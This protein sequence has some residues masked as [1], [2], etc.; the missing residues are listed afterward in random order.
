MIAKYY[1]ESSNSSG[2]QGLRK[3]K[4]LNLSDNSFIGNIPESLSNLVSLEA[5][6]LKENN[7]SGALQNIGTET[8]RLNIPFQFGAIKFYL[9]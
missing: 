6:N 8:N 1:S 5:I 3:L 4:Y 2:L 7:M 9:L